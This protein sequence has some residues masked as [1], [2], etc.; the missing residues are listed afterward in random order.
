[1]GYIQIADGKAVINL[2]ELKTFIYIPDAETILHI[3]EGLKSG[4]KVSGVVYL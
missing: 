1:M 2:R 4:W 3:E